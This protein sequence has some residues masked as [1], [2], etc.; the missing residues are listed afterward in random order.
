MAYKN[1]HKRIKTLEKLALVEPV[2][3]K[4]RRNA[5]KYRLT[6]YGLFQRLLTSSRPFDYTPPTVLEPYMKKNPIMKTLLYQYFEEETVKAFLESSFM[7]S[8][9]LADYLRETCEAIINKLEEWK[10]KSLQYNW[11]M[12]YAMDELI[13]IKAKSFISLIVI[14]LKRDG[15]T[16][17]DITHDSG[18]MDQQVGEDNVSAVRALSKDQKFITLLMNM[19]DDFDGGCKVLL[20]YILHSFFRRNYLF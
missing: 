7:Y 17:F 14:F 20:Y 2:E 13:T 12:N 18:R 10:S 15:Y 4:F 6:P 19:K 1:V 8:M 5:I 11:P 3:G 9:L 16:K